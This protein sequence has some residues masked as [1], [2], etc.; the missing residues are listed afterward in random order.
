MRDVG[1]QPSH[2][3]TA[4]EAVERTHAVQHERREVAARNEQRIAEPQRAMELDRFIGRDLLAIDERAVL[5]AEVGGCEA[6]LTVGDARVAPRDPA[7]IDLARSVGA[8]AELER[9]VVVERK[10]FRDRRTVGEYENQP[11]PSIRSTWH[12]ER[13][14]WEG[15]WIH[16]R[17]NIAD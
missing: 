7:V 5:A 3:G 15:C 8:A 6:T 12:S 16:D 1:Q 17:D 11:R 9:R 13:A 14:R 2:R 10:R 4:D